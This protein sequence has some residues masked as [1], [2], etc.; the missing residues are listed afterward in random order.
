MKHH[1]LL[2]RMTVF[3]IRVVTLLGLGQYT[4]VYAEPSPNMVPHLEKPILLEIW[5]ETFFS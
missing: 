3:Q 1:C 5:G 2:F 4:K